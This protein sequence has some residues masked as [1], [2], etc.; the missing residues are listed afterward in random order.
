MQAH[1]FPQDIGQ[2]GKPLIVRKALAC[3]AMLEA[4]VNEENSK[5]TNTFEIRPD[6]LILGVIPMGSVGL[7][8]VFSNYLTE[9][10]KRIAYFCSRGT[11][12]IECFMIKCA[13]NGGALH[14]N[15]PSL[16][17]GRIMSYGTP[18]ADSI[19]SFDRLQEI[20]AQHIGYFCDKVALQLL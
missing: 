7:G 1:M 3:K 10:E 4:M 15:D 13:V 6:E 18:H 9:E 8:K 14:T 16:L 17:R 20:L 11:E 2:S 12:L 19:S 5:L